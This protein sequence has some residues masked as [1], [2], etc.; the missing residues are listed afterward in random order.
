MGQ[1]DEAQMKHPKAR[2]IFFKTFF[3]S[4]CLSYKATKKPVSDSLLSGFMLTT[5]AL[6]SFISSPE[7]ADERL[8]FDLYRMCEMCAKPSLS[9]C[10]LHR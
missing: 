9:L 7:E 2:V 5:C 1:A 4:L 6:S 3:P 10:L 8:P